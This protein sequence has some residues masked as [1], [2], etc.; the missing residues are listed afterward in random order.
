MMGGND[1]E[2]VTSIRDNDSSDRCICMYEVM[3]GVVGRW[4]SKLCG[5]HLKTFLLTLRETKERLCFVSGS[6]WSIWHIYCAS[7]SLSA[8]S[9]V[10]SL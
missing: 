3:K 7:M 2:R 6:F 5:T 9:L 1:Q 4:P 10:K 8:T